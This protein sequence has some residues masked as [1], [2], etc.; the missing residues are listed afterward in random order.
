MNV[1]IGT[2]SAQFLFWEQLFKNFPY[3]VFVVHTIH[4]YT[5]LGLHIN[6]TNRSKICL[7]FFSFYCHNSILTST[8]YF[9]IFKETMIYSKLEPYSVGM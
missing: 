4:V 7:I 8:K 6:H 1:D 3:Y 2:V 5:L 9:I